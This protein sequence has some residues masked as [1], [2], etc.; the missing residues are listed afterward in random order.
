MQVQTKTGGIDVDHRQLEISKRSRNVSRNFERNSAGMN[1]LKPWILFKEP[2]VLKVWITTGR[3]TET[4]RK[5][6][7]FTDIEYEA[8]QKIG[9]IME[10]RVTLFLRKKYP[11]IWKLVWRLFV[12]EWL[13][14][15]EVG[16]QQIR[17]VSD[18]D[19]KAEGYRSELVKIRGQWFPLSPRSQFLNNW[20]CFYD[21]HSVKV[22]EYVRVIK[23]RRVKDESRKTA[24]AI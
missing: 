4:R 14:I 5:I 24:E 22:N 8:G 21:R 6:K 18:V 19:A 17:N 16:G 9:A 15:M 7:P 3:K 2:L 12:F 13:R 1:S 20:S 10:N 11:K 23:F